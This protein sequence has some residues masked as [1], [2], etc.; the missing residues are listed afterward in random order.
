[1][2]V[3][4]LL[5]Q[6]L[7]PEAVRH[8][9]A[10]ID[11]QKQGRLPDAIA[12]FKKVTELAP[13]LP[14][15]WVNLGAAYMQDQQYGE[16]IPPLKKSLQLKPD[17]P[18]AQQMLGYALLADGYAADAIPYLEETHS[19]DAL[20]IAQLKVGKLPQAIA[21]LAESLQKRPNDPNLLYYLGRASGLLSKE[22]FDTLEAAYPDSARAHQALAENYAVLRRVPEAEREYLQALKT[23]DRT[24]GI[25]LGLGD[26]YAA[27]ADWP[28]AAEQFRQEAKLQPGDAEAAYKL[29]NAL[30]QQGKIA[31]AKSELARSDHL[32]PAMPETL[33]ALGKA[34]SM[35]GDTSGAEN[36]WQQLLSIEKNSQLAAQTHFALAALYR[37][38][39]KIAE[40]E[41]EMQAYKQL[42]K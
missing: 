22:A 40:A 13:D 35:S 14:A 29:G 15:A 24:P 11:A 21:N 12:E 3:L 16:A 9:Q 41:R 37:K 17:L 6:T 36:A 19:Q 32:R 42:Q 30:L 4:G 7:S 33:Y 18:G 27:A 26:L 31:E 25:H 34:D 8:A 2:V 1:L 10:G 20:G 5:L 39:G 23:E 38:Q 28:K